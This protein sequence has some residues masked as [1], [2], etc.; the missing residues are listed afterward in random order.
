[1][2]PKRGHRQQVL[3]LP[4]VDVLKSAENI[5]LALGPNWGAGAWDYQGAPAAAA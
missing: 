4:L 1:M 5:A 3:T 2:L